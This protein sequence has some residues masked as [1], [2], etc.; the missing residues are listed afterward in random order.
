MEFHYLE[1]VILLLEYK[2][3]CKDQEAKS[4]CMVP[5]EGFVLEKEQRKNDK[6]DQCDYFLDYFQLHQ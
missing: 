2:I 3:N 6:D 4:Y 5:S 1:F